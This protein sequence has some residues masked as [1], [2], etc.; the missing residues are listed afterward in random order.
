MTPF[1]SRMPYED[2]TPFVS[3]MPYEDMTP[4]VSRMPYED[5]TPFVSRMPYEDMTAEDDSSSV[6]PSKGIGNYFSNRDVHKTYGSTLL[7]IMQ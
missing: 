7:K 3:R 6:I 1:V 5:M 4:F 2:M